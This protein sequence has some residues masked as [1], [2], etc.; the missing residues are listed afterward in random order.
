M[1]RV[2]YTFE[3]DLSGLE[4]FEQ[5]WRQIVEAHRSGGHGA[6]ESVLLR[7]PEQPS[8]FFAISR[9]ESR[10]LWERNR[11]DDAHPEAYAVFRRYV[12]VLERSVLE[13]RIA[14][15]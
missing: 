11:T 7:D 13:E 8:R 6:I 3:V 12:E 1:I 15:P 9:W 4:A 14:L 5:A 2:M 10:E